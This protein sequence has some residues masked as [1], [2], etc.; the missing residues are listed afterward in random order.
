MCNLIEKLDFFGAKPNLLAK[1][2]DS[3]IIGCIGTGIIIL[4]S[5]LIAGTTLANSKTPQFELLEELLP[6]DNFKFTLT[7]GKN[8]KFVFCSSSISRL[9]GSARAANFLFFV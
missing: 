1:P 3:S 2:F 6:E 9:V 5:L 8:L 7:S 4:F